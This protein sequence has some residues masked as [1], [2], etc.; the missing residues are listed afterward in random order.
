MDGR[1][2]GD[3]TQDP[4]AQIEEWKNRFERFSARVAC[5]GVLVELRGSDLLKSS[6]AL[7]IK[8]NY[9][10]MDYWTIGPSAYTRTA[11]KVHR[12]SNLL[13]QFHQA[14]NRVRHEQQAG[15]PSSPPVLQVLHLRA[16]SF[17]VSGCNTGSY[18]FIS[19]VR[20]EEAGGSNPLSSTIFQYR[21][22]PLPT[23]GLIPLLW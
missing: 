19:L 8:R 4:S 16:A 15:S 23:S 13:L 2:G 21:Q 20:N 11:R 22:V 10:R 6:I 12:W 18:E 5:G 3:R 1:G 14:E 9:Y 17:D 7:W